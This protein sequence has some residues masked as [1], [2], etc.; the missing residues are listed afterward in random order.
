M[1]DEE[2]S[3]GGYAMAWA[4][5]RHGLVRHVRA[6]AARLGRSERPGLVWSL[7]LQDEEW[8]RHVGGVLEALEALASARGFGRG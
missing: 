6:L 7:V 8:G 5:Q 2:L 4:L 3:R 1:A